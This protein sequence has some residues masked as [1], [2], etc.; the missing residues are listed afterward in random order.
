M[1][2]YQMLKT[3]NLTSSDSLSENRFRK[4]VKENFLKEMRYGASFTKQINCL[5][6]ALYLPEENSMEDRP[7]SESEK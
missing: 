4:E 6:E 1:F 5:Y 3:M 2:D 7:Q